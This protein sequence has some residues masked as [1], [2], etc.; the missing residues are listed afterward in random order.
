M[1]RATATFHLDQRWG[2][3]FDIGYKG[4][5]IIPLKTHLNYYT[6][7]LW[8]RLK[9]YP[10]VSK[11]QGSEV[12]ILP[13]LL[14][15]GT[16]SVTYDDNKLQFKDKL[17]LQSVFVTFEPMQW[18]Q[19]TITNGTPGSLSYDLGSIYINGKKITTTIFPTDV[20]V[21]KIGNNL[22][23][24]DTI[25]T[26]QNYPSESILGIV[27]IYNRVLDHNEIYNNYLSQAKQYSLM[28]HT[29]ASSIKDSLV[30]ELIAKKD[31]YDSLT[32]YWYSS[33]QIINRRLNKNP[34]SK[35]KMNESD[36]LSKILNALQSRSSSSS[37]SKSRVSDKPS[38]CNHSNPPT[39]PTPPTPIIPDNIDIDSNII[40]LSRNP[41]MFMKQLSERSDQ[42]TKKIIVQTQTAPDKNDFNSIFDNPFKLKLFIRY[43]QSTP[44]H[45]LNLLKSNRLS[46]DQL[47]LLSNALSGVTTNT[48]SNSFIE[49]F[50]NDLPND[51]P[52]YN[53]AI[54][55]LEQQVT[56]MRNVLIQTP[57]NVPDINGPY[58][59]HFFKRSDLMD[60]IKSLNNRVTDSHKRFSKL[61]SLLATQN[62]LLG[63]LIS[64]QNGKCVGA[65]DTK[66]SIQHCATKDA[67]SPYDIIVN[68]NDYNKNIA[69]IHQENIMHG[70][71]AQQIVENSKNTQLQ[72]L[73]QAINTNHKTIGLIIRRDG[74]NHYIPTVESDPIYSIAILA[75]LAPNNQSMKLNQS[76][77]T[78]INSKSEQKNSEGEEKKKCKTNINWFGESEPDV[79]DTRKKCKRKT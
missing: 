40:I 23:K 6:I 34:G 22:K 41:E 45:F 74:S 51:N 63:L 28:M 25:L 76:D 48:Q 1:A 11:S 55:I 14:T 79:K 71:T 7:E 37:S 60:D 38:K 65:I 13:T 78:S 50:Y 70:N 67:T 75:M 32:K 35:Y 3:H 9:K 46:P 31:N 77:Q 58:A 47:I 44:R 2:A 27:R 62:N 53:E 29:E 57:I 66:G 24:S 5:I 36:E 12:M 18:F 8:I 19:L 15:I 49:G 59:P 61:E 52:E 69:N 54:N 73:G 30:M 26:N 16:V 4:N 72:I 39:P 10:I 43:L 56:P 68:K 17:T 42:I 64:R 21:I 33:K 20:S